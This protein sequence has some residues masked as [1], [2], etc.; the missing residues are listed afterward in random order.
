[1]VAWNT[2]HGNGNGN[3]NG[4][5]HGSSGGRVAIVSGARTPFAKMGTSLK[6]VHV[7]DL[8]KRAMQEAL[9][10]AEWKADRLD[11]VIL[12][13]VVMPADAANIA[14]VSALYAGVP[15][16]VP[17]LSVQRNCASG[18]EAVAEAALRIRGGQGKVMLAG[19]AESMSS[20]PLL[21]PQEAMEPVAR[22][23]RARS[24]WQR[25]TAVAGLRPR[26]FKPI[27]GL[28]LG[29]TDPTCGMIMGKTT[30]LLVKEWGISR[31]EQD[32]FACRSHEK[33]V[34]A[35]AAGKFD[36]EIVPVFPDDS[37]E[38]VAKDVGPRAGQS[39]EALAKLKPI[40]DRRD[41]SVT[42]GNSCQV[43]DGAACLLVM[44]EEVAKA[45]G[46]E[47]LGYVKSYSY[48]GLDPTRMGLGP[49]FAI[50]QLLRKN[51][52]TLS[53]VPLL[54]INEAFAGQV[55]ACMR[56][57]ASDAFAKEHLNRDKALGEIDPERL[58]VNGGSIALGHPVGATGTRLILTMLHEMKRRDLDL[59]VAS[60]CVGGG[61]GAA[62]LLER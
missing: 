51:G 35:Q 16:Q 43:T 53:D 27:I 50:E 30:E 34:A 57:M 1:M 46:R 4:H 60:L 7:A 17:G 22:L 40:F 56:A 6:G 48:V 10:R 11:E 28:E 33:A 44:D 20:I 54:E 19:G 21:F 47:V 32:E 41:G 55:I 13:N 8:A 24:M 3:G 45:E 15:N 58:N 14:R 26:H 29:L 49:A 52:M 31:S 61:Q 38:P 36:V 9:Y 37:T 42:V 59:G 39:M 23:G 5:G 62:I 25:T 18:M 2:N 12:G